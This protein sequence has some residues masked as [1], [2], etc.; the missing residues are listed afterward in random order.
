M[1]RIPCIN[2]L[3]RKSVY[4]SVVTVK[5]YEMYAMNCAIFYSQHFLNEKATHHKKLPVFLF[6]KVMLE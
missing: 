4:F 2:Q 3:C 1:Y 6:L 5:P